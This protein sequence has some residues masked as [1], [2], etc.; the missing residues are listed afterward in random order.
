MTPQPAPSA[1]YEILIAGGGMVGAALAIA[2]GQAGY[3]VAVL[4]KQRPAAF[5]PAS[6]PDVR[7]SAIN[8]ASEGL[9]KSWGAWS[10]MVSQRVHPYT[11][12][13]VWEKLDRP[14]RLPGS[15]QDLNRTEFSHQDVGTLWLGHIIENLVVQRALLQVV[16]DMPN[17][18]LIDGAE[19]DRLDHEGENGGC[20]TL[21]DGRAFR[22][23]LIIGADGA[24]SKIREMAELGLRADPYHQ[25]AL[26]IAVEHGDQAQSMTWQAFTRHGPLAFLPLAS[27]EGKHYAS[28]VWYDAPD[29][30]TELMALS[31]EQLLTTLRSEFP[32]HLPPLIRITQRG[33]F[34]LVKRHARSYT[35]AG[36]ALVGDAAHTINPL[37]GQG[38][39]LGFQDV[40]ALARVLSDAKRKGLKPGNPAVLSAYEGQRRLQNLAMMTLMDGFYYSFSNDIKPLKLLRNL[41]L[42]VAQRF[43][44][45]KRMVLE[46]ATGLNHFA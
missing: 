40:A 38:V 10:P 7:V 43:A 42:S 35:K 20:L 9:L 21:S 12:L 46:Y 37:A 6:P 1:D 19:I 29:R 13:A 27:V 23:Q 28:L 5:D 45:A 16:D 11:R 18:R 44:P 8:L 26:V 17:V 22:G 2:L 24:L 4:E 36:V 3:A 41:G 14:L 39:N 30:L 31:D 33:R 32:D 15:T 34:P 25:H